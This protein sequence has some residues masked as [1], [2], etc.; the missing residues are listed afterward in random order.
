MPKPRRKRPER[1]RP[2]PKITWE[3]MPEP[4]QAR[5]IP[6]DQ[7]ISPL[8]HPSSVEFQVAY[9]AY[10]DAYPLGIDAPPLSAM[11]WRERVIV[12]WLA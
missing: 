6:E 7:R 10:L 3:P 9:N 8:N 11:C 5:P 2:A 4:Y 12:A 1:K